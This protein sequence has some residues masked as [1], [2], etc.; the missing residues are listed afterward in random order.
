LVHNGRHTILAPADDKDCF[1]IPLPCHLIQ[2]YQPQLPLQQLSNNQQQ[3]PPHLRQHS[4]HQEKLPPH[5]QQL[6]SHQQ[7]LPTA[8]SLHY[9]IKKENAPAAKLRTPEGEDIGAGG[10]PAGEDQLFSF[11]VID[12]LAEAA[13]RQAV[14]AR[15]CIK[16][17]EMF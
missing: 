1:F 4:P 13:N 12:P 8:F 2:G 14:E 10:V 17:Q 5:Q 16:E 6:P 9:R 11:E 7:L 3:L 15:V